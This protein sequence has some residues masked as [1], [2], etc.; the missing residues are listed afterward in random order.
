MDLIT[1]W[2]VWGF[3]Q[4]GRGLGFLFGSVFRVILF[5]SFTAPSRGGLPSRKV[6]K[7]QKSIEEEN[8]RMAGCRQVVLEYAD[9][10]G[11]IA[12]ESISRDE[13]ERLRISFLRIPPSARPYRGRRW[14]EGV[15]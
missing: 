9:A 15:R 7:R 1:Q 10:L 14:G 13:L 8:Q 2:L 4:A 5:R 11:F 3:Y 12:R 6:R